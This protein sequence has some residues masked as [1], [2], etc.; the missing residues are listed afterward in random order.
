MP[1]T[2]F[3]FHDW[4]IHW[5]IYHGGCR[6]VQLIFKNEIGEPSIGQHREVNTLSFDENTRKNDNNITTNVI[7]TD[8]DCKK[9]NLSI[10]GLCVVFFLTVLI[11]AV[12]AQSSSPR[13]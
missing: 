11:L 1:D 5:H 6:H 2:S 8:N 4:R 12:S 3:H 10:D 13:P 9:T 7:M